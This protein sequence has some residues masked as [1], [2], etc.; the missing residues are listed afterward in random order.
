MDP[1]ATGRRRVLRAGGAAFVFLAGCS[2]GG[3]DETP[4]TTTSESAGMT[5]PMSEGLDQYGAAAETF[6]AQLDE[7]DEGVDVDIRTAEIYAQLEYGTETLEDAEASPAHRDA[8]ETLLAVGEWLRVLTDALDAYRRGMEAVEAGTSAH[9]DGRYADAVDRFDAASTAFREVP[10]F[11]EEASSAYSRIDVASLEAVDDLDPEEFRSQLA[12]FRER[13]T[14]LAPYARSMADFV[15]AAADYSAGMERYEAGVSAGNDGDY[16]R[17]EEALATAREAFLSAH[18]AAGE[19]RDSAP[20]G[21]ADLFASLECTSGAY[22]DAA[23]HMR[24][25]VSEAD[26]GDNGA[27][28]AAYEEALA[29]EEAADDC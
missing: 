22:R 4:T 10:S 9:S 20:D 28:E 12:S 7:L 27:A 14:E 3:G 25:A 5:A 2:G 11:L 16:G 26:A 17:S 1:D 29:A 8:V 23:G 13:A 18:R 24:T 15:D 6:E 19:G 21:P